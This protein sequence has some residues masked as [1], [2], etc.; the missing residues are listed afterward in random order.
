MPTTEVSKKYYLLST[1]SKP[2]GLQDEKQQELDQ[3]TGENWLLEVVIAE[4]A[5]AHPDIRL[6]FPGKLPSAS[7]PAG[8]YPS[9]AAGIQ[10]YP[11]FKGRARFCKGGVSLI[12]WY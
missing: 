7:A 1:I 11:P 6:L 9:A 10:G 2:R 4:M 12:E 3:K 5:P 8:G